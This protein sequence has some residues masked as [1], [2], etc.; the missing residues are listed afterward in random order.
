VIASTILVVAMYS[1]G[2]SSIEQTELEQLLQRV[3]A[4]VDRY[5]HALSSVVAEEDYT[6]WIEPKMGADLPMSRLGRRRLW[7]DFLLVRLPGE[8]GW[9]PYRDVF[10]VDGRP[11]RDRQDRLVSLLLKFSSASRAQADRITGE[12]ARFNI[13][14]A[15]TVNVPPF[16]LRF[17]QDSARS[18]FRFDMRGAATIERRPV[19]EISFR[20]TARPT[21]IRGLGGI[22]LPASG[23][24]WVDAQGGDVIRTLVR[25]NDGEVRSEVQ[26]TYRPD[27]SLDLLVP[28]EMSE[29]Y[30]TDQTITRG[31]ARY[32]NFRRFTVIVEEAIR[33]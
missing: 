32:T 24:V 27:L 19:V 12:S 14:V 13:G 3:S 20:E 33:K 23:T 10:E 9:M 6:Q 7:A 25:T 31:L 29:R 22:D 15:R 18:R 4:Y 28:A 1:I 16:P 2:L 8:A 30:D 5:G 11:V 21:I 17:L 26:V